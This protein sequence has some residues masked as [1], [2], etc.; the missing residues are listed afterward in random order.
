MKLFCYCRAII[1]RDKNNNKFDKADITECYG[2]DNAFLGTS[3]A[4]D[5]VVIH[6]ITLLL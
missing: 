2:I 6:Y 5:S 3:Y 1:R 4:E